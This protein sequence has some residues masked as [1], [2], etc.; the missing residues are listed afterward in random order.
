M[1]RSFHQRVDLA[2]K[3]LPGRFRKGPALIGLMRIVYRDIDT[4]ELR[5]RSGDECVH[6]GAVPHIGAHREDAALASGKRRFN[7]GG[8]LRGW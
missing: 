3:V 8:A 4:A 5:R 7:V 2:L 6:L 1:K